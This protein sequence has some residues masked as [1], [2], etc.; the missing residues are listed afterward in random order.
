MLERYGAARIVVGHTPTGGVVWPR[1]DGRVVVNDP[2]ISAYYGGK[3]AY[4]ELTPAGAE[5]GYGDYKLGL[6]VASDD[7]VEYLRQV[8]GLDP[9]N[10][11]LQRRLARMLAPP[12]EPVPPAGATPLD[13]ARPPGDAAAPA[14]PEAPAPLAEPITAD[15]CRPV[16]SGRG[17]D[18]R[19][20]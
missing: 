1:F 18:P 13:E 8:I 5:A 15:T 19:S 16:A 17:P 10:A 12:Q 4:L 14:Q 6:P 9:D 2:G 3:D 20:N 7:R 11:I